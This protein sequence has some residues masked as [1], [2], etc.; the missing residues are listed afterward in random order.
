MAAGQAAT[1]DPSPM[2]P[3]QVVLVRDTLLDTLRQPLG[4]AAGAAGAHGRAYALFP[5][6]SPRAG[7]G[8]PGSDHA[9][10]G[11]DECKSPSMAAHAHDAHDSQPG[12]APHPPL[13]DPVYDHL[14]EPVA[15]DTSLTFLGTLDATVA[16]I[17]LAG[18]V[19]LPPA[20]EHCVLEGS[21]KSVCYIG[22]RTTVLLRVRDADHKPVANLPVAAILAHLLVDEAAH[23]AGADGSARA[24]ARAL[25]VS[26]S[27]AVSV[28]SS[29]AAEV[30]ASASAASA[31]AAAGVSMVA[32]ASSSA[33]AHQH[34]PDDHEMSLPVT[35]TPVDAQLQP[36]VF[37]LSYRVSRVG[38]YVLS[39]VINGEP[40]P[41][42]PWIIAGQ[43]SGRYCV[44]QGEGLMT[45]T[46]RLDFGFLIFLFAPSCPSLSSGLNFAS[47]SVLSRSRGEL[48]CVF[49]ALNFFSMF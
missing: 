17:R 5:S 14:A 38:A 32:I 33:A 26:A 37:A 49:I 46:H 34:Q 27:Q 11:S 9:Q 43:V 18:A 45:C 23:D 16:A 21:G 31:A 1:A 47:L 4:S 48:F 30:S 8:G 13:T 3:A 10:P 29:I 39:V 44:V 35:V 12:Q 22:E 15:T 24:R 40:L 20:V 36:G 19:L 28:A 7:A 41:T 42:G 6:A 25:S 2:S